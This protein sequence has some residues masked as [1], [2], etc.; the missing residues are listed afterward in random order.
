MVLLFAYEYYITNYEGK[1]FVSKLIRVFVAHF[2]L[3]FQFLVAI[4][5][6]S[7]TETV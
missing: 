2:V 3:S 1:L 6:T 4:I 7:T 5:H